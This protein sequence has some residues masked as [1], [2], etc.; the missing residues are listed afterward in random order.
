[1]NVKKTNIYLL[2][3]IF[4]MTLTACSST[5]NTSSSNS[6][7]QQA[8]SGGSS[9]SSTETKTA[10]SKNSASD[11]YKGKTVKLIVPYS[12][13]GGYDTTARSLAPL[14]EK[15]LGATVLV[16]NVPGAGGNVGATKVY[17]SKPDGLT[18]GLLNGT[19]MV[20]NV[21]TNVKGIEFD[22]S[23]FTFIARP[24]ADTKLM[25]TSP[26]SKLQSFEDI[27]NSPKPIKMGTSGIGDDNMFFFVGLKHALNL[28]LE[29]IT[30]YKGNKEVEL[31]VMNGEVDISNSS[32]SSRYKKVK[33]GDIKPL[34]L[35]GKERPNK[36][37]Y[38]KLPMLPGNYKLT[39]DGKELIESLHNINEAQR[40][41]TAPPDL[42]EDRRQFL[43]DA[44][45]KALK[46]P[47]LLQDWDK[48]G[49]E[50]NFMG[51]KDYRNVI[52][53]IKE[54]TSKKLLQAYEEEKKKIQR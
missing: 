42:P 19:G 2:V 34:A 36:P 27:L 6:E 45:K 8:S 7:K 44:L 14:L 38:A 31:A 28:P 30:G 13:G 12:P 32:A 21:L 33:A 11:F 39:A 17:T 4:A 48:L 40:V 24:T 47:K 51:G 3:L 50:V 23:K 18:I 15:E 5:S 41:F 53:Q 49:F 37:E 35:F 22:I 26:S 43:E 20:M 9:G 54:N 52:K 1:M 29:V 25:Y 10:K 16:E 46:D